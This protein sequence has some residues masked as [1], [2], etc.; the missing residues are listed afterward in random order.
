MPVEV[1]SLALSPDGLVLAL[2]DNSGGVRLV[3]AL[4]G[5]AITT[6][7]APEGEADDHAWSLAF[8]PDGKLLAVGSRGRVRLWSLGDSPHPLVHLPGHRS[9]IR[10][11]AFSPDGRRLATSSDDPVIEVWDLSLI[12]RELD[13]LGVGW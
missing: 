4:D 5:R 1:A 11:I 8:S 7:P 9:H 3:D 13:R 12:H 10:L 2:G 6:L